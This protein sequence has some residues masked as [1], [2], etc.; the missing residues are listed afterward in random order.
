MRPFALCLFLLLLASA[1]C[2]AV[3]ETVAGLKARL[4]KARP[5]ECPELCIRIAE[6][7]LRNA[8]KLYNEGH[9][10]EA[11]AAIDDVATYSEKARDAAIQ[12]NK[13]MKNVEIDARKMAEKLR[14]LKRT[15]AVEDQP[16]V[17][18]A[19]RRLEELR[20]SLLKEM[21]SKKDKKK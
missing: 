16:P 11:Q 15:L 17:E 5:E 20:T 1:H 21:F 8:D 14:D 9:V 4:E 12:T 3:E 18:Q 7:Q 19:I 13:R 2:V 6:H 10:E